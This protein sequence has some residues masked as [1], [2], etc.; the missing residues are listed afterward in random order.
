MRCARKSEVQIEIDEALGGDGAGCASSGAEGGEIDFWCWFCV[1]DGGGPCGCVGGGDC[2]DFRGGW[3]R[4]SR[5]GCY[6]IDGG[7]GEEG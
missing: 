6:V 4:T 2:V 3:R 5:D 7:E 1:G